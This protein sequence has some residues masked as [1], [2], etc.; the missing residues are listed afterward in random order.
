[1]NTTLKL[2]TETGSLVNHLF[3]G[4]NMAIPTVGIG[5]TILRWSDRH[6]CTIVEVSKNGKRVGVTED[7]AT[8]T[9]SNGMSDCQSYSY[10]S[11]PGPAHKFFTLR[12]NG[13]WVSEGESIK[14]TRLAIGQRNHYHDYSF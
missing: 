13:A 9:D 1:M 6:A 11:V 8:R 5:A 3:S 2:G 7:I 4:M 10:E 12:K 14:G